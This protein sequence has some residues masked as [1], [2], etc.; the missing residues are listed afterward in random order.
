[1]DTE[2]R[3]ALHT[4]TVPALVSLTRFLTGGNVEEW[5]IRDQIRRLREDEPEPKTRLRL[6]EAA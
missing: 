6:I 1:M 3:T 4:M 2:A 5:V